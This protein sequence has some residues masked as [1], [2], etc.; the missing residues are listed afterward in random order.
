M[1]SCPCPHLPPVDRVWR[2]TDMEPF[3]KD[4]GSGFYHAAL[5]YAQSLWLEGKPA[6]ALLQLNKAF[7][8]DLT[9]DEPTLH[10]W[11]P[12]YAAKAWIIAESR[13]GERF[14]GNPV[15]HYQHL[16]TRMNALN[17]VPRR[18]RAWACFHLAE[19]LL[20]PSFERDTRQIA[21]ENLRIPSPDEVA[22]GLDASGWPGER[23][24]WHRTLRR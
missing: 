6:Q 16:A 10:E 21:E 8:A 1:W 13:S 2:A 19:G 11:H 15:R 20:D 18:W 3:R 9:G 7:S 4:R 24:I 17:P 12:P 22:E 14:L 5:C 23:G